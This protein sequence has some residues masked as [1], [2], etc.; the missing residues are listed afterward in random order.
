M[1]VRANAPW[2]DVHN[3]G[4]RC[5]DISPTSVAADSSMTTSA[6]TLPRVQRILVLANE[7]ICAHSLH[8][9]LR[10]RQNASSIEVLLVAP[11]LAGRLQFWVSDEDA[12]VAAAR[13]RMTVSCQAL[14]DA[15]VSVR[16]AIG[17]ADPLLALDDA[18]RTFAPDEVIIATHVQAR[19]NWLERGLVAQARARYDVPIVHLEVLEPAIAL[20]RMRESMD[21]QAPARETHL[22]R[23][24]LMFLL[25]GVLAIAGTV[26]TAMWALTGASSTF[27][28]WWVLFGDLGLKIIAFGIV[29]LVFQRRARADRLDY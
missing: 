27:L 1:L 11:A 23:D 8:E 6:N 9:M 28:V 19:S 21:T 29:W 7:T 25:A 15:G 24:W 16:G 17:D 4:H 2:Y 3:A 10:R 13:E 22:T 14:R 5:V 18:M 20:T 26:M 12:G